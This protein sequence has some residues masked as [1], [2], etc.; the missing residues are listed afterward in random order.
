MVSGSPFT[1]LF[2]VLFTFPSQY[3]FTIGLSVV[4]SLTGWCRQLQTGRLRPRHTQDTTSPLNFLLRGYHP[5]R[6]AFPCSSSQLRFNYV[7]LNP[8]TALT[9]QVWALALSL[10]TTRA[11]TVVF[12][13]SRYLDVSV[14]WVSLLY[15][16]NTS[17]LQPDRLS[18]SDICGSRPIADPRSFSQLI[19]SFF[20]SES[21][22]IPHA[23]FLTSFSYPNVLV[24]L[25]TLYSFFTMSMNSF[26]IML[27]GFFLSSAR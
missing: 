27:P 12:S 6:P 14:P 19:T 5:L 21:L 26:G 18:H 7:V 22:G 25:S 8:Q 13:S 2:G 11:I 16:Y 1:L 17:G 9:V 24:K 4:F 10:A 20:A 3:W 23:P 15:C